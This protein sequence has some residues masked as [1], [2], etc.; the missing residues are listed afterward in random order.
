MDPGPDSE[1]CDPTQAQRLLPPFE[2]VPLEEIEREHL[3]PPRGVDSVGGL[4]CC[5]GLFTAIAAGLLWGVLS[6]AQS[7]F[8]WMAYAPLGGVGAVFVLAGL[9]FAWEIQSKWAWRREQRES[10]RRDLALGE[11]ERIQLRVEAAKGVRFRVRSV[12]EGKKREHVR[13][14]PALF[15]DVGEGRV[16]QVRSSALPQVQPDSE[17]RTFVLDRVEFRATP[18]GRRELPVRWSGERVPIAW[19]EV[20]FA[21]VEDKGGKVQ[22]WYE[23]APV[24]WLGSLDDLD[25]LVRGPQPPSLFRLF[26]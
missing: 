4:C 15:L 9:V 14:L 3:H 7:H 19:A 23:S 25:S 18:I 24:I 20:E 21:E 26:G 11:V 16:V 10:I 8:P 12:Q 22:A 13:E 2:R 17:P 5:L 1:P 6:L